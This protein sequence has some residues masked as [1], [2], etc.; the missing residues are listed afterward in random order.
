MYALPTKPAK[1]KEHERGGHIDW[2][3]VVVVVHTLT[4]PQEL[5]ELHC[6]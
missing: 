3:K 6:S 4:S 5:N 1:S 2:L